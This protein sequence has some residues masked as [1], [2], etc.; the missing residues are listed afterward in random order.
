MAITL[1]VLGKKG[2]KDSIPF[3]PFMATGAL[4]TFLAG[5]EIIGR[6]QEFSANLVGAWT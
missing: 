1:L 2:R 6:Y 5:A 4:V 3:G